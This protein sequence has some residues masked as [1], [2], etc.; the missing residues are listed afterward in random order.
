MFFGAIVLLLLADLA[1]P[2]SGL[3]LIHSDSVRYWEENAVAITE[4][5]GNVQIGQDSAFMTCDRARLIQSQARTE[6]FGNVKIHEGEKWLHADQ[7]ISFDDRRIR[8]ASGQVAMGDKSSELTAR[9]VTYFQN[10]ERALAEHDVIITNSERRVVLTCGQAEYLRN[11]EYSRAT[12]EPVLIEF[13]SMQTEK[14]RIT[15]TV[16]EMFAGGERNKVSGQVEITRENTRAKCDTAEYFRAEGRLQLRVQ[17]V[18]WQNRDELRGELIELFLLE[19][20]LTHAQVTGKAVMTS[21]VDS[22]GKDQRMNSL[23]GGKMTLF[24]QNEKLE[25]V[26][27]EETATS[28]YHVLEK[29]EDQGVNE[30]QGDRITLFIAAGELQRI[31]I[32][33]DPGVSNGKYEPAGA[34]PLP[35]SGNPQP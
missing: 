27:V 31:L 6:F 33:S 26:V 18:T 2:Q 24:F 15:G 3:H 20:K 5:L 29:G 1:Q 35:S 30:V 13:D 4:A 22:T 12:I 14:L 9:K 17:P 11:Q 16:I 8:V 23:S 32:T 19:Q 10:E 28:V 7:V 25:H 34:A 21:P